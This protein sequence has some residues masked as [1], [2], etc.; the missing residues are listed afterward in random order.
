MTRPERESPLP[1]NELWLR[2]ILGVL[3][4]AFVAWAG[5]VWS[6]SQQVITGQNLIQIRLT[7]LEDRVTY[8]VDRLALHEAADWHS[9]AGLEITR[10]RS[11]QDSHDEQS[12]HTNGR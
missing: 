5:V 8:F 3:S 2:W 10:I 11:K 9:A 1:S 4:I 7:S 12:T 6:A